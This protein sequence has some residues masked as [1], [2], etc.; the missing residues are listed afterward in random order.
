MLAI[1]TGGS[2]SAD[3]TVPLLSGRA[4]PRRERWPVR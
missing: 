4:N 3:Y 2:G 1:V